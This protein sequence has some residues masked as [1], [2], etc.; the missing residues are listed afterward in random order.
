MFAVAHLVLV[1]G[2]LAGNMHVP[3]IHCPWQVAPCYGD[4]TSI[5]VTGVV[6]QVERTRHKYSSSGDAK[7]LAGRFVALHRQSAAYKL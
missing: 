5:G 2:E 6:A 1:C 7:P 3:G 4:S